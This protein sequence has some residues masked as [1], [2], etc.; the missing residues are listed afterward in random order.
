MRPEDVESILVLFYLLF[1]AA[2]PFFVFGALELFW[3]AGNIYFTIIL[4]S[5]Y[6]QFAS[7]CLQVF[8]NV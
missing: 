2:L 5:F 3:R 6:K 7:R 4:Q 1:S 8:L